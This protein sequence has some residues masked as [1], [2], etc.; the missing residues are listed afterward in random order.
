MENGNGNGHDL[1]FNE[2]GKFVPGNG[3]TRKGSP[4][5]ASQKVKLAIVKFL[6]DNVQKIQESFDQLEP[7]EKLIFITALLPYAAHRL[8]T[9]Q[10]DD[11]GRSPVTINVRWD[12][13]LLPTSTIDLPPQESQ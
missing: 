1:N 7:R 11:A 13:S 4:N 3:I 10:T 2:R 9:T 6:E 5:V 8:Q 12:K